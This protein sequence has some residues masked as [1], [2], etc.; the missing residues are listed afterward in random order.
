[1]NRHSRRFGAAA[2]LCAAVMLLPRH[3]HGQLAAI[4]ASAQVVGQPLS[5]RTV[6]SSASG[7]ELAVTLE[8]CGAG[9]ITVEGRRSD[10]TMVR[11]T[12]QEL[13]GT[14]DCQRRQL[15]LPL[16]HRDSAQLLRFEVRLTQTDAV[17][18]PSLAQVVISAAATR[19][20]TRNTLV[21]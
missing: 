19:T 7:A 14:G 20:G 17:L 5:L 6:T 4:G 18:A 10:G 8:G 13:T 11:V 9:T 15:L 3:A 1:M 12:R 2:I 16:V 21:H